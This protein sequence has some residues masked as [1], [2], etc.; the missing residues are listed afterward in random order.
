IQLIM[1]PNNAD[2]IHYHL[3]QEKNPHEIEIF[4]TSQS[5]YMAFHPWLKPKDLTLISKLPYQEKVFSYADF[6]TELKAK[7]FDE[8]ETQK[9][10]ALFIEQKHQLAFEQNG[11]VKLP[12]LNADSVDHLKKFYIEHQSNAI[13][14]NGF[15]VSLDDIQPEHIE[16]VFNKL[17]ETL[18]PPLSL[19]LKNFKAFTASYVVKEPG[20]QNVVPPHQDW[21][22]VDEEKFCSATVWVALMDVTKENGALGVIKGSNQL[23]HYP[24]Q[25]PSPETQTVLSG[26]ATTLF[27]Y[28]DIVEMRAGEALIFDNRTIH[29]S[30]TNHSDEA[31]I[32]AGIGITQKEA[33][34]LHFYQ[35]PGPEEIVNVYEVEDGFF[36]QYNNA[37]FSSMYNAGESPSNLKRVHQF[38]KNSPILS[39]QEMEAMILTLDAFKNKQTHT[40]EADANNNAAKVAET[41]LI[42]NIDQ[43]SFFEK[44]TIPN[45]I[46]EIQYRLKKV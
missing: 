39:S 28:I 38:K 16:A 4:K 1:V 3:N 40:Q 15:H 42:E 5:F 17:F 18:V 29:A 21:T 13:Q 41:N 2:T 6:L 43:R 31:R 35:S 22:F 12:L 37:K 30:P 46:A 9:A 19:I 8:L 33:P 14:K 25:S 27:K 34:L 20:M 44:Y 45:I 7:R 10:Q 23:F 24:R 32:G 36:S 11:Y 26:H